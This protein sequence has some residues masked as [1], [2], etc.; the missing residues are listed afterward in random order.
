MPEI[1]IRRKMC[2]E[3][4]T[5]ARTRRRCVRPCRYWPRPAGRAGYPLRGQSSTG[6]RVTCMSSPVPWRT[7]CRSSSPSLGPDVEPLLPHLGATL[8]ETERALI[9]QRTKAALGHRQCPRS[10]SRQSSPSR[11]LRR[12][13]RQPHSGGRS[14]CRHRPAGH[15]RGSGCRC[16]VAQKDRRRSQ[17]ARHRHSA[18]QEVGSADGAEYPPPSR[19]RASG[20]ANRCARP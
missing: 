3:A 8:A 7:V 12:H 18:G 15:S 11:R 13:Q 17:R 16:D 1:A 5:A 14:A 4:P 20:L 19:V 9:S 6:Y 10:G 2:V